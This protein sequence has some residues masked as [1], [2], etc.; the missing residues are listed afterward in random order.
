MES[1]RGVA[2][3]YLDETTLEACMAD[4]QQRGRAAR[5][6]AYQVV[7]AAQHTGDPAAAVAALLRGRARPEALRTS[8]AA[9]ARHAGLPPASIPAHRSALRRSGHAP[10]AHVP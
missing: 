7:E 3:L 10:V 5:P 9:R 2:S 6:P 4:L 8:R 1:L